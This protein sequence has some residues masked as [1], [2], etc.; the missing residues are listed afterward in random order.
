MAMMSKCSL[1]LLE[2]LALVV[3]RCIAKGIR[4]RG[5]LWEDDSDAYST[6]L[7]RPSGVNT[8]VLRS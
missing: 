3:W 7:R 1:R 8:G 6:C 4:R 2:V 5:S